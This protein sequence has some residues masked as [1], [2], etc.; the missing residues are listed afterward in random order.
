MKDICIAI[1][2]FLI[3]CLVYAIPVMLLWNCVIPEVCG[4]SKI[5]FEQAL[6]ITALVRLLSEDTGSSSKSE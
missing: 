3:L 1:I 6:C 2:V 4:F 5:N